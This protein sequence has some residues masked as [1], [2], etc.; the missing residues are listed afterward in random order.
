MLE[1]K[2][3]F[4]KWNVP[5]RDPGAV[6]YVSFRGMVEEH[7]AAV[8][9]IEALEKDNESLRQGL[10]YEQAQ[11]VDWERIGKRQEMYDRGDEL[12]ALRDEAKEIIEGFRLEDMSAVLET[13]RNMRNEKT[14]R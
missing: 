9:M 7:N 3:V 12:Y 11:S 5:I 2:R 6:E 1:E 13:L 10:L 4:K 14:R 8:D